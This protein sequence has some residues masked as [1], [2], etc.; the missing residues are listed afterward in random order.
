MKHGTRIALFLVGV[1]VYTVSVE[2]EA[3]LAGWFDAVL[4]SIGVILLVLAVR[5]PIHDVPDPK[6]SAV[7]VLDTG[8]SSRDRV[9]AILR[10][11]PRDAAR[12]D[13]APRPE[14]PAADRSESWIVARN[15]TC[16]RAEQTVAHLAVRGIRAVRVTDTHAVVHR[17]LLHLAP[18]LTAPAVVAVV[19]G[20]DL[21]PFYGPVSAVAS[22]TAIVFVA[23]L[24][25]DVLMARRDDAE[26]GFSVDGPFT[27]RLVAVDAERERDA[28]EL[29]NALRNVTAL[30]VDEARA[31]FRTIPTT[32]A[33]RVTAAE[34][35]R[36]RTALERAGATIEVVAQ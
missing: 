1:L 19:D 31:L 23:Y 8:G 22:W 18:V 25:I 6:E 34:A 32:V 5:H 36:Y 2:A 9:R 30:G 12:P 15:L 35:H 24:V 17:A 13:G 21:M 27:V 4:L 20:L 29:I 28:G 3:A 16:V 26:P 14:K 10:L 33:D 7:R 11:E